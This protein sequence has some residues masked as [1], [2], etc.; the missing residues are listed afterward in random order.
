MFSYAGATLKPLP[1]LD[2]HYGFII[3]F[4]S[5]NPFVD[6]MSG[7]RFLLSWDLVEWIG[8]SDIPKQDIGLEYKLVGKWLM[9]HPV[10][11]RPLGLRIELCWSTPGR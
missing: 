1:R 2:L 8:A 6:Y 5:M 4:A 9:T 11:E 10:P 3:R 7:K